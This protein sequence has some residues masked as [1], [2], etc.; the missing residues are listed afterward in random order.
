MGFIVGK[1]TDTEIQDGVWADS[2]KANG[3][4]IALIKAETDKISAITTEISATTEDLDQVADTYDLFT[5]TTQDVVIESLLIRLPN[6]D[7]SDDAIIT[8]ISIQ[9]NDVTPGVFISAASGAKANLTAEAEL[10]WTGTKLLKVA[11][12]IQLTIAGGAADV[13]TVCDI[14]CTYRAVASGGHLA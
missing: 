10:G 8:S 6:V 13:A 4:D 5:G 1:N 2:I 12:K 7:V 14:I 3:A 11:K 9:T